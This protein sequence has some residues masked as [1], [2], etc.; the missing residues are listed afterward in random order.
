MPKKAYPVVRHDGEDFVLDGSKQQKFE[1]V[2]KDEYDF[3]IVCE[4]RDGFGLYRRKEGHGGY[5]YWT[6]E[7]LPGLLVYDEGLTNIMHVFEA[8][9]HLE[10]GETM[11]KHIGE[12]FG[13][14]YKK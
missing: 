7:V 10:I 14:R 5:S 9:D 2:G 8:M 4:T 11:W 12:V 13:Y 6:D 3:E 1:F